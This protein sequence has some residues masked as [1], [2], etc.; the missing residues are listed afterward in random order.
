MKI[1][2]GIKDKHSLR[3]YIAAGATEFYC[4][5]I[6]NSWLD[7]YNYAVPL[8]RRPWREANFA[9]FN[10]LGEAVNIAHDFGCEIFYTINEHCYNDQQLEIIKHH[11][12]NLIRINIDAIIV[13]DIGLI[14][15][16][17]E[18]GY[19][20]QIHV[21]TGGIAFNR[22]AVKF[23]KEILRVNRLILPRSLTIDEINDITE[24]ESDIDY[25]IF[26]KNE[27]CTYIDGLCNFVHGVK[28]IQG[29]NEKT[30]N[31]PCEL[32]YKVVDIAGK[33]N[34]EDFAQVENRLNRVLASKA[35]CGVCSLFLFNTEKIKSLKVVSRD[36]DEDRIVNDILQV[37]EA[38]KLCQETNE[39]QEY[40]KLLRNKECQND[41]KNKMIYCYYPEVCKDL[42]PMNYTKN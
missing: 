2:T 15:F 18:N 34:K 26:I 12:F 32:R 16:L 8:N 3:R 9:S 20:K 13:S 21:S 42:M 10:E 36:T 40:R 28:Y 31:P 25:E 38:I 23:Y 39:F 19:N 37:K 30:Y 33:D 4:G 17:K 22:Y 11:L 27:G 29:N 5:V 7:K 24:L 35:N 14:Q 6:D 1:C 41:Y